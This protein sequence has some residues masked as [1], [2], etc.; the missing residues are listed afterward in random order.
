MI[1]STSSS[2]TKAAPRITVEVVLWIS[3]GV[4]AVVLRLVNLDAAPLAAPEARE[5]ML[6][7]RAVTGQGMPDG[8]YS[9]FLFAANV[10]L[11]ALCGASDALARLWPVLFGS[12]LVFTPLLFRQRIGR[13]GV[14]AAGLYLAISPT[15]LFASR[16][17]DG[18]V[19]V[20]FWG[21]VFFGGSLRF[22]ETGNKNWLTSAAV[23]LALAVTSAPSAYG[24]LLSLGLAWLGFGWS[25]PIGRVRWLWARINPHLGR[26]LVAF[27]LAVLIFATGMGW[28]LSGVGATGDLLSAWISRFGMITILPLVSLIIYEPLGWL[29]GLVGLAWFVWKKRRLGLLLGLWIGVALLLLVVAS[30]QT[31]MRAVW[32]VLPLALLSGGAV[33]AVVQNRRAFRRWRREWLYACIVLVLWIYLYLRLMSYGLYGK[34]LDLIVG[35]LAFSLPLL[36]A[37][38]AI[39][40]AATSGDDR[41]VRTEIVGGAGSALR[42]AAAGSGIALLLIT[43]SIG[44]GCAQVRPADP[45]E[46]LVHE[47]TAVEVRNLVQSLQDLSWRETGLPTTLRITYEAPADSVLA[48]YMRD[49]GS[50][51]RV[52][53]LRELEPW[54]WN[55]VL[56]TLNRDWAFDLPEGVDLVGRDFALSRSWSP[57][58]LGCFFEW[59]PCSGAVEWLLHRT[60]TFTERNSQWFILEPEV[61]QWAVIWTHARSEASDQSLQ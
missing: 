10:F 43:F 29:A 28:N 54:E 25:W 40:F 20:A 26:A 1:T 27:L 3:V 48:W 6:A 60:P 19:M 17:L 61:D 4:I 18:A 47:S 14:L 58:K 33:E 44:W 52:D 16:Q 8:G 59:P 39:T 42:G 22:I 51:R 38:L 30:P 32:V 37:L 24:M 13:V 9:P 45:R 46:L 49:F 7:W 21:T 41:E 23:G 35:I 31:S 53:D 15:A 50:A 12:A 5:A 57:Q 11:F 56:V 34:P 2:R 36:L 55:T